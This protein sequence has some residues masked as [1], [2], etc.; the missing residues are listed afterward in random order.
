MRAL[1]LMLLTA[2][3]WAGEAFGVWKLNPGRSALAGI[4]R[5]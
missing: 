5:V 1:L 4:K 2:T 3:S